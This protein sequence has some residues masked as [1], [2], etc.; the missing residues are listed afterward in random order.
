MGISWVSVSGM[1]FGGLFQ[2]GA[3]FAGALAVVAN[4]AASGSIALRPDKETLPSAGGAGL[5][6]LGLLAHAASFCGAL[7]EATHV[8]LSV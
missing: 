1:V 3:L 4:D 8:P 5:G 7:Q 6:L 2:D